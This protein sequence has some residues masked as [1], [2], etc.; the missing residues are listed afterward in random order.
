MEKDKG[1]KGTYQLLGLCTVAMFGIK[2]LVEDKVYR[3]LS[4]GFELN[5]QIRDHGDEVSR[6]PL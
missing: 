1:E 2:R 4:M 5:S 6:K 3:D